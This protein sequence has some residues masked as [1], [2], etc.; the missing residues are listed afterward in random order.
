MPV[1]FAAAQFVQCTVAFR[2][3]PVVDLPRGLVRIQ[4]DLPPGAG[5]LDAIHLTPSQE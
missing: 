2:R 3:G 5:A 4:V 1:S